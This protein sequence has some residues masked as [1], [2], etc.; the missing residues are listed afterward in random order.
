MRT[1]V[2][3]SKHTVDWSAELDARG[4]VR[5]FRGV[6]AVADAKWCVGRILPGDKPAL[7]LPRDVIAELEAALEAALQRAA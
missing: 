1:L 2:T 5:L 7:G 3:I 4:A 6:R